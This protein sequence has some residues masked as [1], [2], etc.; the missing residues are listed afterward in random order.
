MQYIDLPSPFTELQY[1]DLP[2]PSEHSRV[3]FSFFRAAQLGAWGPA[4]LGHVLIPASSHQLFWSPKPTWNGMFDR[5]QAE[6]T[7]MQFRGHFLPVHQSMSVP[8]DFY[9]VP[10]FQPSLP[11]RF[12][13]ITAIGMCYFLPV[14]HF[15]MAC[16]AGSKVNIQQ[17]F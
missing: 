3:S 6:I 11:T 15:G 16:L 13:L 5:H 4:S 2:S 7:V 17:L 10:F 1:I 14:L 12:L 9:L 8:S